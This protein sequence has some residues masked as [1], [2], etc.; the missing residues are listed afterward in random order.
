MSFEDRSNALVELLDELGR[1]EEP[2]VLVGGYAVSPFNARFSTDLDIVVAP[3]DYE[4]FEQ[5][6]HSNDFE[7][8]DSHEKHWRYATAVIEYEKRLAPSRPIGV[9]LLVNGLGYR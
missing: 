8:L 3:A 6:L 2:F 9:D 4:L 5:F 1:R 7:R